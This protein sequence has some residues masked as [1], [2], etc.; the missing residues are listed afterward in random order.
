VSE[1]G[2]VALEHRP[3]FNARERGTFT[4]DR[5]FPAPIAGVSSP[6]TS[7]R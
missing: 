3:H 1:I 7:C 2:G 6:L 5:D 4:L